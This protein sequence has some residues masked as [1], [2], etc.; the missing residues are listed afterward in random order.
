MANQRLTDKSALASN[1][2]TGDLFLIVDVN[3]TTGSAAGT[4]K[5]LDSSYVIQTDIISVTNGELQALA[6]SPRT[7]I[8]A[9]GSGYG[10][11]PIS[12]LAFFDYQSTTQGTK[13]N[14]YVGH[15][16]S[17]A[18]AWGTIAGTMHGITTDMTYPFA[19][20][21]GVPTTNASID[22]RAFEMHSSAN[23]TNDMT[24]KIF[25]TYQ[26]LKLT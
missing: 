1:T 2:G 25:V 10:I 11:I 5:K 8:S 7:L 12:V 3:D 9:P 6:G 21:A 20:S 14:T 19:P 17:G 18:Y 23:F 24:A 13:V 16:G 4:S 15:T 22:D 26:I